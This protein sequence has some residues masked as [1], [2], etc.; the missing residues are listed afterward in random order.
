MLIHPPL[1]DDAYVDLFPESHR[2]TTLLTLTLTC[3][4]VYR[5]KHVN[6]VV[7]GDPNLVIPYSNDGL[8]WRQS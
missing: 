4:L 6:T 2:P 3:G 8:F 1:R 7:L 5:A